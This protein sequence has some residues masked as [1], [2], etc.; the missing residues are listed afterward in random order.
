MLDTLPIASMICRGAVIE[1]DLV[2][3]GGRY[4]ELRFL[5]PDPLKYVERL[6]LRGPSDLA[7][8][9]S[10]TFD[11]ILDY[12]AELGQLLDVTSNPHMRQARELTYLTAPTTPSIVDTFYD[13][14]HLMFA[15][16]AVR[17][18]AE[19]QVGVPYLEGWV[20]Q[21][22]FDGSTIAVRAFG[23]RAVHIVAGNGPSLSALTLIRSAITRG[24]CIIKA[25]S[26]DPFTA[27]GIGKTMIDMAPDHP[28]TRH[29]SAAY[30]RGGDEEFE[31]KLYQPHNVEK[32]VAWGGLASVKHVTKYI[33]PGLELISLDPKRSAS[34]IGG[35]VLDDGDLMREAAIRLAADIG[36]INQQACASARVAYVISGTDAAAL[37]KVNRFAEL[38]YEEIMMMP[39]GLS[40]KPKYYGRELRAH[41]DALRLNNEFY[42]VIGGSDDEGAIIVSQLPEAVDFAAHLDFRTANIVPV[43]S[44]DDVV[45]AV[46]AY[47]QTVGVYPE[48][49]KEAVIDILPLYGAQRFVS[50]GAAL[51]S[52]M[53]TP[54]DGIEPLRRMCKWVVNEINDPTRYRH[55]AF[56][57]PSRNQLT[58]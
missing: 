9:Y 53:A 47:T 37:E 51:K 29:Y 24:D 2:E 56:G 45:D 28:I 25:P 5:A 44:I 14:F 26:N 39:E 52:T 50:L 3:F 43:D 55:E 13:T 17:D 57:T 10:I 48:S 30:W 46:D 12:L 1:A 8:L 11:Q 16:D 31:R 49:L 21:T 32:I 58:A 42:R 36:A 41:V 23:S 15:P 35:E 19:K 33:Q 38:V 4:G 18:M 40:T 20:R 22:C 27:I 34:I 54:Q 6:A 7:D